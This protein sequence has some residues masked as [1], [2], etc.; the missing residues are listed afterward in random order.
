[1]KLCNSSQEIVSIIRMQKRGVREH[2]E[3]ELP[4]LDAMLHPA[5]Y[6]EIVLD[7]RLAC[8][9]LGMNVPQ[10]IVAKT[11]HELAMPNGEDFTIWSPYFE[12]D[13]IRGVATDKLPSC[14]F[15]KEGSGA[16]APGCWDGPPPRI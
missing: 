5:E 6:T 14:C 16:P 8:R 15:Q 12:R 11:I 2:L 4:L 3:E 10:R 13:Y 1:M 9:Q 7:R